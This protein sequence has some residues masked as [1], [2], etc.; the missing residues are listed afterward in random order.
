MQKALPPL[1]SEGNVDV[2]W[3]GEMWLL[4]EL[5]CFSL[6]FFLP[7]GKSSSGRALRPLQETLVLPV[8][9]K[10]LELALAL[11]ICLV[12][13]SLSLPVWGLLI[14]ILNASLIPSEISSQMESS[15]T[16]R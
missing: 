9:L 16:I 8:V 1:H 13:P 12:C 2:A 6:P 10:S 11:D 4:E 7:F 5:S 3:R 14:P 15:S